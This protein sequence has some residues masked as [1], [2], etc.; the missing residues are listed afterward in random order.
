MFKIHHQ[1]PTQILNL[2]QITIPEMTS[3]E[4]LVANTET[5]NEFF[6]DLSLLQGARFSTEEEKIIK[7]GIDLMEKTVSVI[8]KRLYEENESY[9]KLTSEISAP[10]ALIE[11]LELPD[12]SDVIL[13]SPFEEGGSDKKERSSLA[14]LETLSVVID[15]LNLLFQE[16]EGLD[17][18]LTDTNAKLIDITATMTRQLIILLQTK[19]NNLS[20]PEGVAQPDRDEVDLNCAEGGGIEE[21]DEERRHQPDDEYQ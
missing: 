14:P 20:Q 10:P 5:L 21:E 6:S 16:S 17:L 15:Y 11:T 12:P 2:P 13:Q 9:E 1:L 18:N 7:N 3:M 4:R 19:A 8:Q